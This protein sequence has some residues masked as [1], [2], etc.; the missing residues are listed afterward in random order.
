MMEGKMTYLGIAKMALAFLLKDYADADQVATTV[1]TL[2]SV[3]SGILAIVGFVE[4]VYGRYRIK[5]A[6][7]STGE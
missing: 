7:Y 6:R 2:I 4:A 3:I 5:R 1:D